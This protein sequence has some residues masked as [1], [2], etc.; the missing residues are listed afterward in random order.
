MTLTLVMRKIVPTINDASN[1]TMKTKLT[2]CALASLLAVAALAQNALAGHTTTAE[3]G[4]RG[5]ISCF[6]QPKGL[7]EWLIEIRSDDDRPF[8]QTGD[9]LTRWLRH[10]GLGCFNCRQEVVGKTI[11]DGLRQL[12]QPLYQGLHE[13]GHSRESSPGWLQQ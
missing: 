10:L 12:R 11:L 1:R 9:P 4:Y 7:E 6:T 13:L 2:S 8:A 3:H 5:V